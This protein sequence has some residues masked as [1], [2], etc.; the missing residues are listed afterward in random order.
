MHVRYNTEWGV[1]G[2]N[3]VLDELLEGRS[4]RS[5]GLDEANDEV[6]WYNI[7]VFGVGR[8]AM[9]GA[10]EGDFEEINGGV[11]WERGPQLFDVQ[12]GIHYGDSVVCFSFQ[13]KG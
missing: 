11:W 3:E 12:R 4:E 2:V 10:V 7:G 6:V 5:G 9:V 13:A 1:L 8:E